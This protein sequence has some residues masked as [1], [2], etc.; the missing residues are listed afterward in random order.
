MEHLI[1]FW[2]WQSLSFQEQVFIVG[3]SLTTAIVGLIGI[4]SET[5]R[6]K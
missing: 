3:I 5:R 2:F 4:Y 6:R 1:L